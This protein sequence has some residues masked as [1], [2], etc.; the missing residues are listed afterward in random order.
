MYSVPESM[1]TRCGLRL[2]LQRDTRIPLEQTIS[3][4]PCSFHLTE[5]I[6]TDSENKRICRIDKKRL[7]SASCSQRIHRI[8]QTGSQE[9]D[10]SNDK[11]IEESRAV[12]VFLFWRLRALIELNVLRSCIDLVAH[13][14]L[15]ASQ[16]IY[17]K[18][19]SATFIHIIKFFFSGHLF[20][21]SF[22]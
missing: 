11:R 5:Y 20:F 18:K 7:L 17:Y 10:T 8:P 1:P 2:G 16:I 13:F 9:A 4:C 15:I 3:T 6:H 22:Y 21:L 19:A 14:C 12:P